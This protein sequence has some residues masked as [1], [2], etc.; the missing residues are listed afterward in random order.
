[1]TAERS[2]FLGAL[3]VPLLAAA[4]LAT[5][6]LAPMPAGIPGELATWPGGSAVPFDKVAHF[7]LYF[8]VA[9]PWHRSLRR[10]GTGQV[11][12]VVVTGGTLHAAFLERL[13]EALTATR[14]AEWGDLVAGALGAAVCALWL[15]RSSR[16]VHG[17][18]VSGPASSRST[19]LRLPPPPP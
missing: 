11:A 18:T 14:A 19:P 12:L 17:S 3:R 1:M 13:Q 7:V 8:V 2:R 9:W 6:L 10:L 5:L 16:P 4:G 15:E